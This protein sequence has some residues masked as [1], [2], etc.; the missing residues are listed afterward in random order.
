MK[1]LMIIITFIVVIFAA[2]MFNKNTEAIV[3]TNSK[4]YIPT[5]DPR[6]ITVTNSTFKLLN[7]RA[8]SIKNSGNVSASMA[9]G[10]NEI[11]IIDPN[12]SISIGKYDVNV[13]IDSLRF[14]STGTT[15]KVIYYK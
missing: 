11:F 6:F 9:N 10:F 15:L 4:T 2:F 8:I 14:N 12:E 13:L 5:V 3:T 1:S 7:I